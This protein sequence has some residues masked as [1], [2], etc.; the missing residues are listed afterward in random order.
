[1]KRGE[2]KLIIFQA[3]M[4]VSLFLNIFTKI[5]TSEVGHAAI[6][7][8]FFGLSY[9]LF[10]FEKNKSFNKKRMLKVV[11]LY[12]ISF[13]IFLYAF[14]LLTGYESS[15]YDLSI[16]GIIKN[17]WSLIIF[18]ESI[19]LLRY[20][21]LKKG[22][23]SNIV[24]IVTIFSILMFELSLQS[25]F[26]DFNLKID[27]VKYLTIVVIPCICKSIVL[28]LFAKK[29]GYEAGIIYQL[30][31][32]LY[33]FII[34]I[35][36]SYDYFLTS[37]INFLLPIAMWAFCKYSLDK[38]KKE[39]VRNKHIFAKV[40]SSILIVLSLIVIGLFS[41]L[42]RFWIAVIGSGSMS[43]TINVGDIIIVDKGVK[44]NLDSLNIGDVLV[45][46]MNDKIYTHRIIKIDKENNLLSISTKGDRKGNAVDSWTVRN[47]NIIGIARY[48]IPYIGYPTVWLNRMIRENK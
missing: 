19:E 2:K 8:I 15:S 26:Y 14:G 36:P 16:F 6:A 32:N 29:Y 38:E 10:G 37:V 21:I 40:I 20:N 24:F 23:K 1:M 46:K 45:F 47:E 12:A 28:N 9:I 41:N 17:I 34:P 31:F 18:Y 7:L 33:V 30:L 35:L 25:S 22:E 4:L 5:I 3:I 42:F 11:S 13:L 43:P 39:D 44:D 27:I 48:R